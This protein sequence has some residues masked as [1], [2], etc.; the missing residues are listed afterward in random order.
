MQPKH[1]V[2]DFSRLF[3]LI[4]Q[5]NLAEEAAACAGVAPPV[6]PRDADAFL[7]RAARSL[8]RQS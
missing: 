8:S 4:R 1:D 3:E 7:A 5:R 2:R 6:D